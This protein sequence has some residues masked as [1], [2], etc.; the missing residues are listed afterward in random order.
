MLNGYFT[1]ISYQKIDVSFAET[2]RGSERVHEKYF[3]LNGTQSLRRP[4]TMIPASTESFHERASL[5][6]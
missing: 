2:V 5:E 3:M 4:L 1:F 6:E